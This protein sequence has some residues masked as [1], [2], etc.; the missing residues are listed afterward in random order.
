MG[1]D[2]VNIWR[3]GCWQTRS[4]HSGRAMRRPLEKVGDGEST[5]ADDLQRDHPGNRV[6]C[7]SAAFSI[8]CDHNRV[9]AHAAS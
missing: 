5:G 6:S 9:L 8:L 1:L 4:A 3:Q 2:D 7:V